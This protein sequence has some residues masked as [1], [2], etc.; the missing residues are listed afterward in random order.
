MHSKI[1]K[2]KKGIASDTIKWVWRFMFLAVVFVIVVSLVSLYQKEFQSKELEFEIFY[3]GLF[4][5]KNGISYYDSTIDR[6]YP[7]I[8][9]VTKLNDKYFQEVLNKTFY[10]GLEN[11][12]MA[13]NITLENSDSQFYNLYWFN[14]FKPLVGKRGSGGVKSYE[15]TIPVLIRENNQIK[16][17]KITIVLL[18]QN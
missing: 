14:R 12:F 18:T 6:V 16:Q 10:Y 4:L 15:K 7:E 5:S 1:F 3:N 2:N 8:V 9:D 11:K 13:A 17:G